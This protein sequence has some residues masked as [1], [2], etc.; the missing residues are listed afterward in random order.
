M[1]QL[2]MH[3]SIEPFGKDIFALEMDEPDTVRNPSLRFKTD[4]ASI[5][6]PPP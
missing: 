2:S 5:F 3:K 6:Q 1:K 4:K